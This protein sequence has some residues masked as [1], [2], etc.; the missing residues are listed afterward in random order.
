MRLIIPLL[1]IAFIT[2]AQS[3]VRDEVLRLRN[4]MVYSE[5]AIDSLLGTQAEDILDAWFSGSAAA[6]QGYIDGM[7]TDRFYVGV[8][9]YLSYDMEDLLETMRE[10]ETAF[11][12]KPETEKVMICTRKREQM[13][14]VLIYSL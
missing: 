2:Q 12:L 7:N 13:V 9:V 8:D 14:L 11:F 6:V 5:P 3:S 1:L 4:V 10:D